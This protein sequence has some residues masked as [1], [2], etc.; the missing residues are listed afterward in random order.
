MHPRASKGILWAGALVVGWG[1]V[2]SQTP[3]PA[4]TAPAPSAVKN[5]SF[6]LQKEGRTQGRFKGETAL[7][8]PTPGL[9]AF[10]VT[11][12]H[13]DTFRAD[14]EP[15]VTADSPACRVTI[16]NESFVVTSPGP[17]KVVDAAGRFEL[18]GEGFHWDHGNQRLV[19][20]NRVRTLI[21]IPLPRGSGS[22]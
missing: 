9:R 19:L 1:L 7:P 14:G 11:G 10:D 18:S 2:R 5:W 17:L 4:P 22:P 8:V 13:V 6:T 3:A 20:S 15:D 12:F 16:T 21:A